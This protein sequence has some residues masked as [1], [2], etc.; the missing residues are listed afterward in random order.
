MFLI[1]KHLY[2]HQARSGNVLTVETEFKG[3]G[4]V[5]FAGTWERDPSKADGKEAELV[6]GAISID[7]KQTTG[8]NQQLFLL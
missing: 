3:K 5:M 8:K 7:L 4:A 1:E 6:F 2:L